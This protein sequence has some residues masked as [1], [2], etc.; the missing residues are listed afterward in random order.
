MVG[1]SRAV[2]FT[3]KADAMARFGVFVSAIDFDRPGPGLGAASMDRISKSRRSSSRP[4]GNKSRSRH[5]PW[6]I[7]CERSGS[8][9]SVAPVARTSHEEVRSGYLGPRV[10]NLIGPVG[11]AGAR[12]DQA[13]TGRTLDDLDPQLANFRDVRARSIPTRILCSAPFCPY[14][15]LCSSPSQARRTYCVGRAGTQIVHDA[16]CTQYMNKIFDQ[17]N[18]TRKRTDMMRG[19]GTVPQISVGHGKGSLGTMSTACSNDTKHSE[20]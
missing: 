17:N 14:V 2:V 15:L 11:E 19:F 4:T 12:H 10:D 1:P 13:T 18:K 20:H 7:D 5:E 6:V 9:Q 16:N 3:A 8:T